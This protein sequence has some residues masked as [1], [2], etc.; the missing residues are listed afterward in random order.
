MPHSYPYP[1]PAVTVD[2]VVVAQGA[3]PKG[4]GVSVEATSLAPQV[5]LI[6]RKNPPFQGQWALPGG[7]VDE[8]EALDV[9]AV[10][11][12]EEETCVDPKAVQ[13]HQLG[14]F[15]DPG[16]DPRGWTVTVAYGCVIPHTGLRV[17]AADDASE[18]AWVLLKDLPSTELAFDHRKV[19]AKSFERLAELSE[20]LPSDVTSKL[21]S[22]ATNLKP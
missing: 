18:V 12:L 15:G 8:N 2:A 19:L 7:F 13:L 11:E 4:S 14:A 16:R 5:L 22:T 6:R 17:E 21:I 1:R 9:A 20:R 3:A 10:R